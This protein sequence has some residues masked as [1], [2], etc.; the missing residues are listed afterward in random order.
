MCPDFI[1]LSSLRTLVTSES[2]SH[3]SSSA[4]AASAR[5]PDAPGSN[6]ERKEGLE[7]GSRPLASPNPRPRSPSWLMDIASPAYVKVNDTLLAMRDRRISRA[8][9]LY[10]L[11]FPLSHLYPI[12]T[13]QCP[14]NPP[15][16]SPLFHPF[17]P[18][19]PLTVPV[20]LD[21][22][23]VPGSA[24]AAPVGV[25]WRRLAPAAWGSRIR[26]SPSGVGSVAHPVDLD[27]PQGILPSVLDLAR[28][29]EQEGFRLG[30]PSR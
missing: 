1:L 20:T 18:V 12:P 30:R 13:H 11:I 29:A 4:R 10:L 24:A 21:T 27:H 9:C 26:P 19:L 17:T 7:K 25:S 8:P 3:P 16:M 15:Y 2:R 28:D 14:R 6:T 5:A 22:H 23:P